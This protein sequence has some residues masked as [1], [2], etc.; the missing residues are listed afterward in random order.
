MFEGL[1]EVDCMLDEEG[2]VV[3]V[4]PEVEGLDVVQV[5]LELEELT[6]V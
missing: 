5:I 4:I 6:G 3:E 2:L 1:V